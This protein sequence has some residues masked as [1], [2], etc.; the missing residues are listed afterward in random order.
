MYCASRCRNLILLSRV[1]SGCLLLFPLASW[2]EATQNII[3]DT[4]GFESAFSSGDIEGQN[5]WIDSGNGASTARIQNSVVKD[6]TQA[7]RVDRGANSDD[8]WAV[9]VGTLGFPHYRYVTV[10][11]DMNVQDFGSHTA[12]GP[13]FGVDTYDDSSVPNVLGA[14]GVDGS[15]GDVL[16]QAGGSGVLVETGSTVGYDE[17]NHYQIRLDFEADEFTLFLNHLEVASDIFVDG[18]SDTFTDADIATFAAGFDSASQME[19]GAAYFDNFLVRNINPADLN[20]DGWVDGLDLGVL[21]LKFG[22]SEIATPEEGDLNGSFL[23]DGLDLGLLLG[24]WHPAPAPLSAAAAIPEP[25][26]LT[27]ALLS[28]ALCSRRRRA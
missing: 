27:L 6:G 20:L 23:V 21:L 12:F 24:A 11:W 16:Y 25:S 9:P 8:R 18:A 2:S 3:L 4:G 5:G 14:L 22:K 15:T 26:T 13:F 1:L 10:D 19:T 28:L 17:W 7:V